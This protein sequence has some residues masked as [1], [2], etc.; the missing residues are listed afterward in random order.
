[1]SINLWTWSWRPKVDETTNQDTATHTRM[2]TE[3]E[4]RN[5]ID[6]QW[7]CHREAP[8]HNVEAVG[9]LRCTRN[10]IRIAISKRIP[11]L[12]KILSNTNTSLRA[13]AIRSQSMSAFREN[14]ERITCV[15]R[16]G[17][18]SRISRIIGTWTR[19]SIENGASIMYWP[20]HHGVHVEG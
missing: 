10:K 18:S 13:R 6:Q 7:P 2:A 9:L 3:V 17:N 20:S 19:R 16:Y 4:P 1:M 15:P 14:S 12:H 11:I 8:H 5:A